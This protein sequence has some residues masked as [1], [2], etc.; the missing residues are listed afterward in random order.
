MAEKDVY[1]IEIDVDGKAAVRAM[2]DI[3]KKAEKTGKSLKSDL[4]GGFD[5]VGAALGKLKGAFLAITAAIGAGQLFKSAIEG[6]IEQEKAVNRLNVALRLSGNYTEQASKDLQSFAN[7]LQQVTTVGDDV[8]LEMLS[9]ALTFTKT[10]DQAKALYSAALDLSAA[11]GTDLNT[12]VEQ[13]GKTLT[14]SVGRL[15]VYE[16]KLQSLSKEQLRAGAGIDLI[17]AKF[18]G[19]AVAEAQTFGAS[20]TQLNNNFGDVLEAIGEFITKSPLF[21]QTIKDISSGLSAAAKSISETRIAVFGD[22]SEK[23]SLKISQLK[24]KI[25]ATEK[26]VALYRDKIANAK[27]EV[28]FLGLWTEKASTVQDSYGLRLARTLPVLN[29]LKKEYESLTKNQAEVAGRGGNV[30]DLAAVKLAREEFAK[31]VQQIKD[32][33][34]ALQVSG[35]QAITDETQKAASLEL[36]KAQRIESINVAFAERLNAIK[37]LA[38]EK[39]Y[40]TD[41][42]YNLAV[43]EATKLRNEQIAQIDDASKKAQLAKQEE[44]SKSIGSTLVSGISSSFQALGAALAKGEDAW[45]AFA[46]SV[47]GVIGD[48]MIQVGTSIIL[49]AEAIKSLQAAI[50]TFAWPAALAAGL[51]LIALG[52]AFKALSGGGGSSVPSASPTGGAAGP[53]ATTPIAG[54]Q[55][56]TPGQTQAININ[57]E[58]TVLDPR[59]VGQQIATILQ[60]TFESNAA[61]VR[62]A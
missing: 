25:D 55:V 47:L 40:I 24:D 32:Q 31:T 16:T 7:S 37:K 22:E 41:E 44:F 43:V 14:G 30:I 19:A 28:G 20:L 35:A 23:A 62:Y 38:Q 53:I 46:K 27:D 36:L 5:G 61:T 11:T 29:A 1:I 2:D 56:A 51:A 4:G 8:S 52:G 50:A 13:L 42:Q 33:R 45:G 49:Q 15:A 6:A 10:T 18:K 58:G 12:A 54:D 57:V 9:L 21:I 34:L 26:S 59:S 48:L 39:Q 3:E 60:E 17:A